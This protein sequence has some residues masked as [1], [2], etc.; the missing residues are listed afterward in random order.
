[1][2]RPYFLIVL[3][4]LGAAV[5]MLCATDAKSNPP[6][7]QGKEAQSLFKVW[8]AGARTDGKIPG[9]TLGP[10]AR[11]VANFIKLNP[12]DEHTPRLAELLKRIDTTHDWPPAEAVALLDSVTAIYASLPSWVEDEKRFTLGGAVETGQRLPAELASAPWGQTQ[13]NGLRVAW[14]LD[15]RAE[16]HR[17]GTPLKSRILFHNAGKNTVVFRALTWNQSGTHQARDAQDAA[18]NIASTYWTTIPRIIACRLAPGEFREVTAAGIGVGANKNDED[19]RGTRVGAWIEAK[20]G[21]DVTFTPAPVSVNGRRDEVRTDGEPGWW[22]E[23]IQERL[24]L[25]APLPADAGERRHLLDRAVRDLFGTAP[26]P[27]ETAAFVADRSPAALEA[28]TR[29]LAQRAGVSSFTGALQS[30]PTKLRVLPADP[31]AAKRPRTASGPGRYP[32]GENVRLVVIRRPSGERI[33]NEASI[34]FFSPDP[35]NP[36]PGAPHELKLPDG[37]DTW[38]AAWARGG[39]VLWLQEKSGVRSC[40]FSNPAKVKVA[41][42]EP[43]AVPADIRAALRG[44]LP[45]AAR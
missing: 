10:L 35:A 34:Q 32:L 36:P 17:L 33:V 6:Q 39:T 15:P 3:L 23:F 8:Q 12:T 45:V 24:S 38:A 7:P 9:G 43:D 21:D 41:A 26:T 31:D 22:L 25:D 19:W 5:A 16:Q 29:R 2:I 1:M 40:D 44:T 20:A 4:I 13:P 37:Y 18:I 11:T 28:L 14:L 27:E 42:V 30:G